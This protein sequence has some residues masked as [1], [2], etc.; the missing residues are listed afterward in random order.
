MFSLSNH[1]LPLLTTHSLGSPK[2]VIIGGLA[3][4]FSGA[5]SMGLGAYLAS[6]TDTDHFVAE[7]KREWAEIREKPNRER[8]EIFEILQSYEVDRESVQ[9]FVEKLISN[10][11]Q[12]VRVCSPS[13][14]YLRQKLTCK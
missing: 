9:P 3:E 4:L 5:I 6:V 10:P 11:T 14:R 1:N 13:S 7:E 12:W 2:L 8:E